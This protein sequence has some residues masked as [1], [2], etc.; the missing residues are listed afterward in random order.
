LTPTLEIFINSDEMPSQ[1]SLCQIEESWV[2]QPFLIREIGKAQLT[3]ILKRE[4]KQ[5][6]TTGKKYLQRTEHI[7]QFTVLK[8][9]RTEFHAIF[10]T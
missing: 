2:S 9:H 10:C 6:R 7:K 5:N 3:R 1:H 4:K 8:I